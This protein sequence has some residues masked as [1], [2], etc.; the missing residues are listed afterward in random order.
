MKLN[1]FSVAV[2]VLFA[3][4]VVGCMVAVTNTNGSTGAR[5]EFH[6]MNPD[7]VFGGN[8]GS[9]SRD[10]GRF[11]VFDTES[12]T[13]ISWQHGDSTPL[14]VQSFYEGGAE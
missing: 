11:I 12:G 13:A 6:L 7:R 5:F 9:N 14:A 3:L 1:S 8:S 10:T 2:G 4:L